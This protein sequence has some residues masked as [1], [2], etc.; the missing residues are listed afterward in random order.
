MEFSPDGRRAATGGEDQTVRLWD[1]ASG[2]ELLVLRGHTGN[3]SDVAFS[4]DG[5]CLA[6]ASYDG[7]NRVYVLPVDD[8]IVLARSRLTRTW[9]QTECRQD[10]SSRRVRRLS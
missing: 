5:T 1:V 6:S 3:V 2:R 9:T 7:T 4:P 8:L 10:L